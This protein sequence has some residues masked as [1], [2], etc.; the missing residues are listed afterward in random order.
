MNTKTKALIESAIMIALS[1]V[2]S[3]VKV[4][5]MPL[6]GSITLVSMLPV[7]LVSVRY[8]LG[9]GFGSAFVYSLGQL[10]LS[11]VF[12]WG[13]TPT[14]LVGAIF[15]DYIGAFTV[16]GIAGI[17]RNKGKGGAIAGIILACVLRFAFHYVSGVVLWTMVDEFV[18]FGNKFIGHPFLYS[19]CYNGFYML[20][21]TV[22]TAVASVILL[23]TGAGKKL[24]EK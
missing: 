24:L 4:W 3:L 16:L 5:E 15:L 12:G 17:F 18:V 21:E 11:G 2:L 20:P 1:T 10:A 23:S 22:I 19:L 6:G 14:I 8:G 9:W 7:M 13:L